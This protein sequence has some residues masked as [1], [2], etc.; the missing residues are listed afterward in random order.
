MHNKP[1]NL[2]VLFYP[3]TIAVVGAS[4]KDGKMGNLFFRNLLATYSGE[5]YPVH[6]TVNEIS[7]IQAYPHIS[8]IPKK[9][10]LLIPLIP[11]NQI[12]TLVKQCVEGQVEVLLAIPSG[13]AEVPE[14]G[15]YLEEELL[16]LAKRRRMRVIG[17][18]SL[19]LLNCPIGLNASMV[20]QLPPGGP[21]FSC[22]TQ[23]GGF[24]MAIYMY[25]HDHQLEI[26]KFCDLGNT[27][28]VKVHELLDYYRQ[29]VNTSIVGA[30]LE[31][32]VDLESFFSHVNI[33]TN[34]KPLILT[35]LGRTHAGRR[36][37]F[38]HIGRS[39]DDIEYQERVR[40]SQIIPAQTG[41]EML[42]IAK[43]MSWQPLPKGRKVGIVTGA[44]G[45]GT[46]LTDLCVEYGLEVPQFSLELQDEMRPHLPSYASV[47]NPVDLTPIWREFPKLYPPLLQ[48]LFASDEIDILLVAI[49]DVATTLEPLMYAIVEAVAQVQTDGILPKPIYVYWAAP[50]SMRKNR[51]ILQTARI[52]CYQS[53]ITSVRIAAA[54]CQY[55]MNSAATGY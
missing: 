41:L 36:A 1:I 52:P 42:D 23:S 30:Y 26:A 7:G 48:T 32:F 37:S 25:S 24:G 21:G 6:P 47:E 51:Q 10:D 14:G 40:D 4:N 18:N 38:A 12:A 28:D 43:G 54:I 8:A 17:P 5:I 2:Q 44:G 27:A 33:L 15:K 39:P 22:V 16:S 29:D 50:H 55:A 34:E 9:I 49:L 46:E 31:S 3:R 53:T 13:F 35:K 20:P 11:A 45:L 19:G